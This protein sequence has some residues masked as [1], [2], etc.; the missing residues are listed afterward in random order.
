MTT[1]P[2]NLIEWKSSSNAVPYEDGL[3][4]METRVKEIQTQQSPECIWF[5]EH[6][7]TFTLGTSGSE[8]DILDPKISALKTGRGG[9][10]T[11]HG[12]GQRII[13]VMLDLNKRQRDIHQ[14][15]FQLEEWIIKVLQ[16]LGLKGERR[17]GRIG[18][19]IT[20]KGIERKIAAIGVRVQKWVTSHGISL[21]ISPDL[22]AYEKILPCG[23]HDFGVTSLEELGVTLKMKDIDKFIHMHCPF[24]SIDS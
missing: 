19:W 17:Q 14:Y 5:L 18:V 9:K 11:Y 10:V 22:K 6:P 24:Q 23:L 1:S 2:N 13:Y 12:P 8:K 16:E 7:P 4:W 20:H 15:V 3:L 21:N